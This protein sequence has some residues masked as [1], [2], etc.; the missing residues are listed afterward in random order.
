[1]AT[2]KKQAA[3]KAAT[4]PAAEEHDGI[5][6]DS[7]PEVRSRLG[8]ELRKQMTALL[9]GGQAH[10]TFDEA[11]KGFPPKLQGEVPDGLPY[12]GWQL[13]EHLRI[14]QRDILDFSRNHDGSY[15]PMKWPEDYW[16][17]DAAPPSA[18][19]WNKTVVQIREDRKAFEQLLREAGDEELV[20][21]FPWGDGQNLLRQALLIADHAAYH[22]G[23]MVV[24]RRLMGAWK[25]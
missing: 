25:P 9:D 21:P 24:L 10:A 3:K 1:M 12:S 16:P 8:N 13:L 14:A 4:K 23:E 6:A 15:K 7:R 2:A 18:A 5:P 19:A 11:I 17:R 20:A 22:I